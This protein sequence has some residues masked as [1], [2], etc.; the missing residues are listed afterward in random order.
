LDI[1]P[2]VAAHKE[3]EMTTQ[4]LH[5]C[6]TSARDRV[7]AK[8]RYARLLLGELQNLETHGDDFDYAHEEACLA[9]LDGA[10]DA[11]LQEINVC[12]QLGLALVEVNR[13]TVG[14]KLAEANKLCAEFDDLTR[15]LD[16]KNSWIAEVREY[17]NHQMHRATVSRN[18]LLEIGSQEESKIQLRDPRSGTLKEQDRLVVMRDWIEKT[19]QLYERLGKSL[20]ADCELP[21][22]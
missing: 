20:R 18:Y 9:H 15:L 19:E 5:D 7:R 11:F 1:W 21:P 8:I 17:R 22:Y 14:Q 2:L 6:S 12:H 3:A 13:R 4:D 16:D 10:V